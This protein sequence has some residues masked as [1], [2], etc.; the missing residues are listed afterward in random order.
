MTV[1][2]RQFTSIH[3]TTQANT[4]RNVVTRRGIFSRQLHTPTLPLT[5]VPVGYS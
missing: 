4:F 5:H 3:H 2:Q 1:R